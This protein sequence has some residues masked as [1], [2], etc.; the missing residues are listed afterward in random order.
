MMKKIL[1]LSISFLFLFNQS[2]NDK[3]RNSSE[4][5]FDT[6]DSYENFVT[7]S[8]G[9]V[10]DDGIK[11][12]TVLV[13]LNA[14]NDLETFGITDFNEMAS[15]GSSDEVNIV[16][17]MD[18]ADGYSTSYGNWKDA[19]RFKIEKGMTPTTNNAIEHLGEINMG[20]PN[21]LIKF[22]KWGQGNFPAKKYFLIIWDHGD[23]WRMRDLNTIALEQEE[24]QTINTYK[25]KFDAK[26]IKLN[27]KLI[28][29]K[30]NLLNKE[31]NVLKNKVKL[32]KLK[33]DEIQKTTSASRIRANRMNNDVSKEIEIIN[34]NNT[35]ISRSINLK[36]IQNAR[37]LNEF[38][39]N[40]NK[41]SR[42]SENQIASTISIGNANKAV[43]H[44]E[45]SGDV[46]FNREIQ[47]ILENNLNSKIDIV[48][49]DA[50]L[51]S[52]IE[53]GYALR[54]KADIMIGSEDL[55]P[56]DG[57][58]YD[59]WLGSLDN[60]PHCSPS[61]LS[62]YVLNSYK[63]YYKHKVEITLSA[64]DLNYVSLLSEKLTELSTLLIDNMAQEKQSIQRS[65]DMCIPFAHQSL[66]HGVDLKTFLIH[67]RN[68]SSNSQVKSLS[69]TIISVIDGMVVANVHS[70]DM[71]FISD[72]ASFGAHGISIYFPE[73]I[74]MYNLDAKGKALNGYEE[75]N[76]NY[77]VEFVLDHKWD[78]LLKEYYE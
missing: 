76:T 55:E 45:S 15:V 74:G 70:D 58:S 60:N 65:R 17:E 44:D 24:V 9:S 75:S 78:N 59:E 10:V 26:M 33:V 28:L 23:G 30:S 77:P 53:T 67:L 52:M 6:E 37:Q 39:S 25:G 73:N 50:C 61:I 7:D 18:R 8:T 20:D 56:G 13:Y 27:E 64:T 38:K 22:I 40:L 41:T 12:W 57:W 14:D 62:E 46:L 68:K 31:I 3:K 34:K 21:E 4:I 1:L 43:S 42:A 16:V 69:N 71:V 36:K 51:M 72:E 2:C 54:N 47:E 32:N 35:S 49:F 5:S 48:G 63:D 66:F 19:H 29:N 11:E